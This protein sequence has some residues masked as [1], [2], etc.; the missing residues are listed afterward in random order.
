MIVSQA[1]TF[2]LYTYY[3]RPHIVFLENFVI[4][5]EN[6]FSKKKK[7]VFTEIQLKRKIQ[8]SL[9]FFFNWYI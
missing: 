2:L 7:I 6:K 4:H 1:K 9:V 8:N 3:Q 5:N